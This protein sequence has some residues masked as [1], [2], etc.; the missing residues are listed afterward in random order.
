MSPSN[1][2]FYFGVFSSLS[3]LFFRVLILVMCLFFLNYSPFE[4]Y[5]GY[6]IFW[7]EGG[8]K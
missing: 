1:L 4:R 2:S 7:G 6:E 5:K 8:A 3:P